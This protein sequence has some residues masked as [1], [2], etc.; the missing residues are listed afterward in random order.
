VPLR[1]GPTP[2][3]VRKVVDPNGFP[4]VLLQLPDGFVI[5]T[6]RDAYLIADLIVDVAEE[7]EREDV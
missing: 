3:G 5:V 6:P 2:V 7:V 4:A 1:K